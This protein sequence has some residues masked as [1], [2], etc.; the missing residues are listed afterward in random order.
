[1]GT[2]LKR[3][4]TAGPHA[5]FQRGVHSCF[6]MDAKWFVLKLFY[7]Q[8]SC[9][10][11]STFPKFYKAARAATTKLRSCLVARGPVNQSSSFFC[12]C[13]CLSA[14]CISRSDGTMCDLAFIYVCLLALATF[15]S[16]VVC[17]TSRASCFSSIA[18]Y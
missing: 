12:C 10:T 2:V 1:M 6:F 16:L 7:C 8:P 3:R 4:F 18:W 5:A 9:P 13:M 15:R 17:F 11:C 14:A